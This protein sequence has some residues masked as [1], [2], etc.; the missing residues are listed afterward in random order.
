MPERFAIKTKSV[1]QNI[2]YIWMFFAAF[3]K[4]LFVYSSPY[5]NIYPHSIFNG[6]ANY[7]P[8]EIYG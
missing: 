2:K 8:R 1:I 5:K 6:I 4:N 7:I 3:N